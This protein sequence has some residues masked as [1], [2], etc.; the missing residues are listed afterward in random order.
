LPGSVVRAFTL[1]VSPAERSL[2]WIAVSAIK[3]DG[4]AFRVWVLSD[5]YPP[6]GLGAA[7]RSI[8]RYIV[9]EG[10]AEA[11]EY[12]NPVTG[13]AV[14]PSMG[15]WEHLFPRAAGAGRVRYL[16]LCMFARLEPVRRLTCRR[17]RGSYTCVPT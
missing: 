13:K 16:G 4:S 8:V 1:T 10:S 9:Q 2:Q 3:A 7:R 12:R 11:R 5:G 15:A 6:P 14:L 17:N